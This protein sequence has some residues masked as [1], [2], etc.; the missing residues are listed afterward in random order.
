MGTLTESFRN[1]VKQS[2][3]NPQLADAVMEVELPRLSIHNTITDPKALLRASIADFS[4]SSLR[5]YDIVYH[6][7]SKEWDGYP[8]DAQVFVD[9]VPDAVVWA[10]QTATPTSATSTIRHGLAMELESNGG[11]YV[12]KNGIDCI[13]KLPADAWFVRCTVVDA[14]GK[15]LEVLGEHAAGLKKGQLYPKGMEIGWKKGDFRWGFNA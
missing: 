11:R 6:E 4:P 8:P 10:F 3:L 2:G 7:A 5:G 15:P 13:I 1:W 9:E 12:A 14:A